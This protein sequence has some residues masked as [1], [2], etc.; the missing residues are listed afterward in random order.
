MR[1]VGGTNEF[2]GRV[3]ICHQNQWGTVCDD[4]WDDNDA[5]VVCRQLG[6]TGAHKHSNYRKLVLVQFEERVLFS[7]SAC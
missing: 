7:H 1:L 4:S 3:E 5:M 2:E 6:N